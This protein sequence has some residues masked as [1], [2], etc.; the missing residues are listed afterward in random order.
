MFPGKRYVQIARHFTCAQDATWA[1]RTG[2]WWRVVFTPRSS[3]FFFI[4]HH[5][6]VLFIL[7][8]KEPYFNV[9]NASFMKQGI[10]ATTV[11]TLLHDSGQIFLEKCLH[12]C[13]VSKL[14]CFFVCIGNGIAYSISSV[15]E[16]R[17]SNLAFLAWCRGVAV[18]H[19]D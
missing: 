10:S 5:H 18:I 9:P 7:T 19:A 8:L 3:V 16:T 12:Q 6:S 15:V 13:S 11:E 1:V 2:G 17:V 4:S 14:E